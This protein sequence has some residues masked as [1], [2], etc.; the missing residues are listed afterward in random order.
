MVILPSTKGLRLQAKVKAVFDF[1]GEVSTPYCIT[2]GQE[3][4]MSGLGCW[5]PEEQEAVWLYTLR[6]INAAG[7]GIQAMQN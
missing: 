6:M 1:I 3:R 2:L 7:E 5:I 4:N